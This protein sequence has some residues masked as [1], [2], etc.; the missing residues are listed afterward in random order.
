MEVLVNAIVTGRHRICEAL[1]RVR[2]PAA[3]CKG[4]PA[5]DNPL[6]MMPENL[7]QL[8][9]FNL[10]P[11]MFNEGAELKSVGKGLNTHR[12]VVWGIGDYCGFLR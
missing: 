2:W 6:L 1:S 3:S 7:H 4:L 9:L 12:R 8:V 5:P 11:E 10:T